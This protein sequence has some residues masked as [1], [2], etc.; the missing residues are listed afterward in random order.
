MQ[1]R[2]ITAPGIY[3][4]R[5]HWR[6]SRWRIHQPQKERPPA[7]KRGM[8]LV[9]KRWWNRATADLQQ[10]R[11][12]RRSCAQ[13]R[14]HTRPLS[15]D[16]TGY[17]RRSVFVGFE[18]LSQAGDVTAPISRGCQ[19]SPGQIK[20]SVHREERAIFTQHAFSKWGHHA[21]PQRSPSRCSLLFSTMRRAAAILFR[22]A[23]SDGV[24]FAKRQRNDAGAGDPPF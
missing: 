23:F 4:T 10:V 22:R 21:S 7:A 20:N 24:V 11:D 18:T 19:P 16:P 17:R 8:A 6:P 15:P 5:A 13:I 2:R 1:V 14:R 12:V 9:E 3:S